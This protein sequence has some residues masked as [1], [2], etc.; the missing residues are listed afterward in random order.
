MPVLKNSTPLNKVKNFG[1]VTL[2]EFE[3]MGI[4][5]LEQIKKMGWEETCRHWIQYYPERLNANAFVGII[6]AVEGITWA[7]ATSEHKAEVR[8][9]VTELRREHNMPPAKKVR[10]KR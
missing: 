3:S 6:T 4:A 10:R 5:T 2:A 8:R 1:R 9:L 7:K